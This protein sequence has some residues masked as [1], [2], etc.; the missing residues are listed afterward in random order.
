ME[1][2]RGMK[3][4][5]RRWVNKNQKRQAARLREGGRGDEEAISAEAG[6]YSAK[7]GSE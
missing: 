7:S 6:S 4:M 3:E 2:D 1:G 5:K